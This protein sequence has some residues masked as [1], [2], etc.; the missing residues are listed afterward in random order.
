MQRCLTWIVGL[1]I[2]SSPAISQQKTTKT[3]AAKRSP[4]AQEL[5]LQ[6]K[7]TEAIR[8]AG[9]TPNGP[10][11]TLKGLLGMVDLEITDRQIAKASA[12]LEAAEKFA[13]AWSK[14]NKGK[15]L[16]REGL[17]GRRLRVQGIELNDKKEYEKAEVILKQALDISKQI[18]DPTLEAGVRNN[19]GH[20]L[21]YQEKLEESAKE[22]DTARQ[23]AESQKDTLRAASYN[24]NLG[25]VL[26]QLD[27]TGP[28]ID[29]FK[30]AEEQGKAASKPDLEARAILN[31]GVAQIRI[32]AS[33]PEQ[34]RQ[35]PIRLMEKA[36]KMFEQQ[37][38][39]R[40][41][42]W[43]LFLIADR[44]AYGMRFADAAAI[45]ER[46]IPYLSKAKDKAGLRRCYFFLM[47]MY[48]RLGDTAKSGKY[49]KLY[50]ETEG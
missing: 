25:N 17:K 41:T 50:D 22:Y 32:V 37:G 5:V 43:A 11:E 15:D 39:D 40:N 8:L 36:E 29:A 45:G 23:I 10:Q 35:E 21:R 48:N 3:Q 24:L 13:D 31:Q 19:L 16:P 4:T 28:A 26:L 42:G 1:T 2:L 6:G 34:L 7:L 30:R 44:T 9:K 27:R 49:K 18:K 14:A 20:A 12:S 46:A 47:D 38:D 33:G